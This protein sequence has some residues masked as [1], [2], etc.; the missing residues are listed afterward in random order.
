VRSNATA[1]FAIAKF[2]TAY[3]FLALDELSDFPCQH[4][5]AWARLMV[6]S[7]VLSLD[8]AYRAIDFDIDCSVA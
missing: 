7:R 6:G 2:A 3:L 8:Q 4:S 1:A 5:P